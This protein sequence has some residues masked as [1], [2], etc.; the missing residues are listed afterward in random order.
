VATSLLARSI[1][2]THGRVTVLDR[3]DLAVSSGQRVGLVGVNGVG[4]STLL[5]VLTGRLRPDDGTVSTMPPNATVGLLAQEHGERRAGTGTG[6]GTE[7]VAEAL[8]RR[9]GVA[10]ATAELDAATAALAAGDVGADDR[11]SDALD[12]WLALGGADLDTRIGSTFATL[13]IDAAVLDR[14]TAVLSGG[15][16][17]RVALAAFLLSTFDVLLLDEPTNDVDLDGLDQLE[18]AVLADPRPMVIVSH[19][20][21][22]L[23]RV[24]TH[25]VEID[26][27]ARTATGFAGGW[28][29]YEQQ[30]ATARRHAEEAF[31]TYTTARDDL[32]RR[33]QREREWAAKG[34]LKARRKA[35][36]NDRNR[37]GAAIESSEQLAARASRTE[38]A[39]ERLEVVDK[40][41]EGW[42]LRF[43]I[44]TTARSGD[45]V[46]RLDGAVVERGGFRLGP[47]DLELGWAER[48]VVVGPNG[49]GKSTLIGALLGRVPLDAGT[50]RLGPGVIVGE[51][52]QARASLD[53]AR[54]LLDAVLAATGATVSDARS[55]LAKFGLGA[56]HVTRPADSVSPGERT[57]ATLAL[58]QATGVN[59]LVLDEPTN[60]LDLP[61]IEQL[62]QALEG[63]AGTLLLVTHDRRMLERVAVTRTIRLAAGRI[64]QDVPH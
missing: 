17:A 32:R 24:V 27:H 14:P 57:R 8:A 28:A 10:E 30:R 36:D 18:R 42:Q 20:R 23:E 33:A 12:R 38:R 3:V 26:E 46:A 63:Y 50:A 48:I 4:K 7:T 60:H 6:T 25:V 47:V 19:D 39:L 13:G 51:V 22:F 40:P 52:D 54:S 43:E 62:E 55:L 64:V 58:L 44:A 56:A 37:L 21:T 1:T 34:V 31:S 29:A 53:G 59:C 35:P 5:R 9:T 16:A 2:V 41:W 45:L 49:S 11:Y 15:E 61:A